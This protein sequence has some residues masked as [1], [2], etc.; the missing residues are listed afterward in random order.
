M[1]KDEIRGY[2]KAYCD[3]INDLVDKGDLTEDDLGVTIANNLTSYFEA[4]DAKQFLID[5]A[6]DIDK[7]DEDSFAHRFLAHIKKYFEFDPVKFEFKTPNYDYDYTTQDTGT[8]YVDLGKTFC[9]D[10]L[11]FYES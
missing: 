8:R 3:Q 9:G 10:W 2:L 4:E 5:A 1:N 7:F 6:N 11:E